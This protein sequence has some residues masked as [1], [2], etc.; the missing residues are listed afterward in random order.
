VNGF[1]PEVF[2][3]PRRL[4]TSEF[5]LE[6]L[7]PGHNDADYAAWT[8]SIDH[9]RAT[10][11][12]EGRKWPRQMTLEENL[13]DLER[14]AN[15]FAQRNGFTYTVLEPETGDVIG[16]VYIY[17]SD[18][19]SYDAHVESW[20]RADRAGLDAPLRTVVRDWLRDAWPFE[21]VDYAG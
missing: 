3:P 14:H 19:A 20:V 5:V 21:R 12:F 13:A 18:E 8:S 11:G 1:V 7:G 6:P 9:I 15:D 10:P 4:E 17:P 16:C 2:E